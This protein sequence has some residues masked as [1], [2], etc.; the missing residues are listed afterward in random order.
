[1]PFNQ[2][3]INTNLI[4]NQREIK[5][6]KTENEKTNFDNNLYNDGTPF[7]LNFEEFK[8]SL[9]NYIA[10]IAATD[11]ISTKNIDVFI[12]DK[13]SELEI[14]KMNEFSECL[15]YNRFEIKMFDLV[16]SVPLTGFGGITI[17]PS[18]TNQKYKFTLLSNCS[19]IQQIYVANE[20]E[21]V[22][23]MIN[24]LFGIT[25]AGLYLILE[26]DKTKYSTYA[27]Q[28][29]KSNDPEINS[30]DGDYNDPK[31]YKKLSNDDLKINFS[32]SQKQ[33]GFIVQ[34]LNQN[35]G[36]DKI[37]F[38]PLFFNES[39]SPLITG[40]DQEIL[41]MFSILQKR[42]DESH[43]MGSKVIEINTSTDSNISKDNLANSQKSMASSAIVRRDSNVSF[44]TDKNNN[45]SV[46]FAVKSPIWEHLD[47]C[48]KSMLNNILKKLGLS[49]DTDSKGTVQQSKSE[50]VAQNAFS[51][52]NQNFRNLVF[53]NFIQE[54]IQEFYKA[55][56]DEQ[57]SVFV[58]ST[59]SLG[60]TEN[61][62][63][64]YVVMG[65]KA[66][67][68]DRAKG[69]S[70][71]TGKNYIDSQNILDLMKNEEKFQDIQNDVQNVIRDG[72][73]DA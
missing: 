32:L 48:Y 73:A 69:F 18:L 40:I 38:F 33:I 49:T 45:A 13:N 16:K 19:V 31:K 21:K 46:D 17:I 68:F 7:N 29:I 27:F 23:L 1:M 41:E 3:D 53:Q 6:N 62:K 11:L 30:D 54:L 35:H 65:L 70:I 39:L 71:L 2:S 28:N 22:K 14:K 64:N 55:N 15:K 51:Y 67:F 37:P 63:M 58:V 42:Y 8:S 24:P 61:E 66:G 10:N 47:S 43:F 36:F 59:Q 25:I 44:N 20:M 57:N 60:M 9:L 56:F 72:D 52:N 26:I 5:V 50:I 12:K 4:K 34:K